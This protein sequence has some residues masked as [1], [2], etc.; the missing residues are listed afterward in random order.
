LFSIIDIETTGLSPRHEKIT[1]IAVF[2]HDG[3][4]VIDELTTLL[5]PEIEIPYRITQ[6]TGI[7][8]KM[9][10]DA[11]RFCDVAK[12][13]IEMTEGTILVGHNVNFDYRFIRKEFSE[14]GYDYRRKLICTCKLSRKL[15]PGRRSYSL[16]KLCQELSIDNPHRHRAYGDAKATL[17]LFELL[18]KV[19]SNLHDLSFRGL[20]TNLSRKN[21]ESL[22]E[23]PGVYYFHN[24]DGAIIYIGKSKN[25]HDRVMSHLTNNQTKK[26]I[27]MRDQIA[28]VSYELTGN[29]LIALLLESNDIKKNRPRFNHALRRNNYQ[30]GL[31][32]HMDNQGY[33]QLK[34]SKN[35]DDQL[36]LTSFSSSLSAKNHLF[37]LA[38][39]FQLCQKLCGLYDAKGACFQY[40]TRQCKGACLSE[41]LPE[42]YNRRVRQAIS[43][44]CSEH[45]NYLITGNGR[46]S[47]EQSIVVVENGKFLGFGYFDRLVAGSLSPEEIKKYIR[48]YP[49]HQDSRQIIRSY[50]KCNRNYQLIPYQSGDG[51][52]ESRQE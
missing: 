51:L 10:K 34:V 6:L 16:G 23:E 8:N 18:L 4:K 48:I 27:E 32:C 31:Y 19:Q 30:W 11:P 20:N 38:E 40:H 28:D 35:K 21:I 5:N 26:A 1:E 45:N 49:D 24:S 46:H 9:V 7:N 14:F 47:D 42:L 36:P 12:Q 13:I 39:A 2:V 15:I 52:T 22:P 25:I 43:P 29:E 37:T 50:L 44:Y 3:E 17:K 41:E 33:L